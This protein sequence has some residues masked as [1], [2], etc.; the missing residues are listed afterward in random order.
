ML[1]YRKEIL[2]VCQKGINEFQTLCIGFK[3]V[4]IIKLCYV[5]PCRLNKTGFNLIDL[6]SNLVPVWVCNIQ[7][8]L[9][10]QHTS[11]KISFVRASNAMD[12]MLLCCIEVFQYVSIICQCGASANAFETCSSAK[13]KSLRQPHAN[14]PDT[15]VALTSAS[16]YFQMLPGSPGA[17]QSALRLCKSILRCSWKHLQFWMWI[18]DTT[19]FDY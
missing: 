13:C 4:E 9:L 12:E 8:G 10:L 15:P 18:Q 5:V 2:I 3:V 14:L 17:L 1:C 16:K 7:R 6:C 11:C 19:G